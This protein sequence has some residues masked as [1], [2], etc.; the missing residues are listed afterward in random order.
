VHSE[1]VPALV[2]PDR[3]IQ[4]RGLEPMVERGLLQGGA[5]DIQSKMRLDMM[6]VEMTTAEQ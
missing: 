2:L 6:I 3:C 4:A 1:R 5:A